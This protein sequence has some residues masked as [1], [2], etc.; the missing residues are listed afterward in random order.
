MTKAKVGLWSALLVTSTFAFLIYSPAPSTLYQK[1]LVLS[2]LFAA[3]IIAMLCA[4]LLKRG[5][6]GAPENRSD[7][8]LRSASSEAQA[9]AAIERDVNIGSKAEL[10]TLAYTDKLTQLGVGFVQGRLEDAQVAKHGS[11]GEDDQS[12]GS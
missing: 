5:P 10:V 12:N 1:L 7:K 8:G 9:A 6:G 11:T 3:V 2:C 4:R